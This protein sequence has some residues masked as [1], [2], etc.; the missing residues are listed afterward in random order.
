[1]SLV[2]ELDRLTG[3]GDLG[4]SLDD[5]T[6][7]CQA[8]AHTCLIREGQRGICNIRFNRGGELQVPWGYVTSLQVDPIE[9]KP[10]YHF[11]AGSD[12]LTFGMLGCNLHCDY[13]QNWL[14]SQALREK[15]TDRLAGI[16]RELSSD[17][18]I[19][20]G[21]QSGAEVVAS[22]Y[23]EPLITSEWAREI[24]IKAGQA[25][26]KQVYISNGF[27]T[28]TVLDYLKPV[29]QGFKVD[30]KTMQEDHYRDLGGRLKPVLD[31]IQYAH[32]Q[33]LWVE[34]VTLIV[35]GFNDSSSELAEI[36]GFIKSVSKNI[37]WHVTAFRP[38][39]K[40]TD[41]P[42]TSAAQLLK[43]VE[44]GK[45][46]GLN[47][48]YAGNMPGGVGEF[49]DTFC[50]NCQ[51]SLIKRQGYLIKEYRITSEGT[52]PDCET[53]IPGV[54]TKHPDQINTSGFGFPR[55]I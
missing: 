33:G 10:F 31:S 44:I 4:E 28:K 12:A 27:A 48:I 13:C 49:E 50:H 30:L 35:P 14:T 47:Y 6:V 26:L 43:A 2:D 17:E 25:G 42:R 1:M 16:I 37:P 24:F 19:R 45:K 21:M 53:S 51:S 46:Q 40:M 55:M 5:K 20:H 29:L 36:A 11:L 54:W 18:I 39:Y 8:C 22:S 15:G 3:P 52:C 41:K 38:D 23:N 32:Q 9:K 7:R 34:I